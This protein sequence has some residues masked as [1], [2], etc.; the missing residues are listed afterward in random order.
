MKKYVLLILFTLITFILAYALPTTELLKGIYATPS[1]LGLFGILY[2]LIRDQAQHEKNEILQKQQQLFNLGATS[3]MAN[4]VFDKHVEFCEKYLQKVHEAVTTL[5][6][7]GPTKDAV[8]LGNGL[9]SLRLEYAAWL[10]DDIG[11]NLFPFEQALRNLGA[12]QGFVENTASAPQYAEDRSKEIH[13]LYDNFK[14]ILNISDKEEEPETEIAVETIKKRV[15]EILGIDDLLFLR[16]A[17]ISE[18][19]KVVDT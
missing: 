14:K 4:V 3:H 19:R 10:T 12:S 2:Q 6:K 1:M 5:W 13:A 17:L 7:E 15:R 8:T 9:Y 18:A 16:K 11:E